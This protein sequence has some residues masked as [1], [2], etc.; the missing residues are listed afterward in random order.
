[1]LTDI[2]LVG[3]RDMAKIY[4]AGLQMASKLLSHL[5]I[6]FT[7]SFVFQANGW[8]SSN[9][10]NHKIA[11]SSSC[12]AGRLEDIIFKNRH[13]NPSRIQNDILFSF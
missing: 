4:K 1:M 5:H 8:I 11:S 7:K 2:G 12:C 3:V 13:I 10:N 9:G 6:V